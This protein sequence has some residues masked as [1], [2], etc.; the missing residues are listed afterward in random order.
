VTRVDVVIPV[1][2]EEAALPSVV[3]AVGEQLR[4]AGVAHRIL[5]VDDGSADGTWGVIRE[6]CAAD[7]RVAGIRLSRRFGKEAAVA[8]GLERTDAD[9]VLVMDGDGQHPPALIPE[10][11]AAWR[12]GAAGV[13]EAVKRDRG[14]E[15]W[16][17]GAVARVFN[18]VTSRL[19][20]YDLRE[21]TDFKLLDR[22]VVEEWR[23]LPERNLFFR[24]MVAWLGFPHVRI[25]FSV[26]PRASGE[27]RFTAWKLA[28]LALTAITAFS[29]VPLRL[30]TIVGALALLF[31]IVLGLQTLWVWSSG[32]AVSG[33]TTVIL[34]LLLLGSAVLIGLGVI[35]EY[36]ARIYQEVKGRP[37]Y[38]AAEWVGALREPARSEDAK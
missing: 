18:R 32:R 31:S 4:G 9:A 17:H 19:S 13:V 10:L 21:A 23:V 27:S 34:L 12:S 38:V 16:L 3:T 15:S 25:P 30:V 26:E 1:H 33:F 24:G 22:A 8:A 36:L 11:L 29:T 6:L 2:C 28:E 7:G 37:R 14:D 20:G 35:G 5:L